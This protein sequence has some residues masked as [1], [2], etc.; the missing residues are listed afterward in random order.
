MMLFP[1]RKP[2]NIVFEFINPTSQSF[3]RSH[4]LFAPGAVEPHLKDA[5][6]IL[7][8]GSNAPWHPPTSDMLSPGCKVIVLEEDPLR[9]RAPFW[10]YQTDVC[11]AGDIPANIS[12]LAAALKVVRP[13]P[14]PEQ[15]Q[16]SERLC[17]G[18]R[19]TIKRDTAAAAAQVPADAGI[20]ASKVYAALYKALPDKS[21][22]VDEIIASLPLMIEGLFSGKEKQ[23]TQVRG[24]AGCVVYYS[25]H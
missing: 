21:Y 20:H 10:G 24:W 19:A 3:P 16:R 17:A 12:S 25:I 8:L 13:L 15:V 2:I 14:D 18:L 5:D 22:I 4:P 11:V 9:P 1:F 6:V 7:V 23:F